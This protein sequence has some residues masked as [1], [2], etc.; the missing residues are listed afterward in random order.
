MSSHSTDSP[1]LRPMEQEEFVLG[2]EEDP[3]DPEFDIPVA[4]KC[5]HCPR[6]FRGPRIEV[7]DELFLHLWKLHEV[8]V[9]DY[10]VNNMYIPDDIRE[11]IFGEMGPEYVSWLV[12]T[13]G[14]IQEEK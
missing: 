13:E 3:D 1:E 6:N 10:L 12:D 11:K 2:V 4:V 8:D 9:L 7:E 14:E 5:P